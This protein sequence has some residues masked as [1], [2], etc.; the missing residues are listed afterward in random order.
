MSSAESIASFTVIASYFSGSF[1]S[2]SIDDSETYNSL[3]AVIV[4]VAT[5]ASFVWKITLP[6][7]SS[8]YRTFSSLDEYLNVISS[9]KPSLLTALVK[10]SWAG[11]ALYKLKNWGRA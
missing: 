4:I 1:T 7:T 8:K 2:I 9:N 11:S 10:S 6:S 3:S 5:P